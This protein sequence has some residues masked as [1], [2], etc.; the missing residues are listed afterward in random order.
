ME[1]SD[2]ARWR[3]ISA[4]RRIPIP[5]TSP[6][7]QHRIVIHHSWPGRE[8]IPTALIP[9]RYAPIRAPDGC[10]GPGLI[11]EAVPRVAGGVD[12]VVVGV[13]DAV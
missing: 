1:W 11:H 2:P 4:L 7:A 10:D 13:E 6:L 12:D 5:N 9:D 8:V 3:P